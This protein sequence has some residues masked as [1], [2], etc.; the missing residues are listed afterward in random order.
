MV[1]F[2]YMCEIVEL[3]DVPS[4]P[5][6]MVIGYGLDGFGFLSRLVGYIDGLAFGFEPLRSRCTQTLKTGPVA[7]KSDTSLRE[8]CYFAKVTDVT[9]T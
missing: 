9:H 3:S 2:R 8:P 4:S 7:P 5:V 6:G 1:T